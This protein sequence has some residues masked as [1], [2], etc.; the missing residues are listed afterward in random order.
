MNITKELTQEHQNILQVIDIVLEE[1]NSLEAGKD[2][3]IDFFTKVVGFIKNYAD[4]YHHAKE[5]NILF[6]AM[7]KNAED[8]H[9]NPIPV[10]LHEHDAGRKFVAEL[11]LA[12]TKSDKSLLVENARGYCYLLQNHIYKE[13]NILYPMAEEAVSETQKQEVANQYEAVDLKNY[14]P[15]D[16][17]KFIEE[18]AAVT[19]K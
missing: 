5:E 6:K 3:N 4:G 7:L 9:C 8:M 14:F 17:N 16:I 12:L 18:L 2:L 1:C 19:T 10:M 13:D 15:Q 11:V